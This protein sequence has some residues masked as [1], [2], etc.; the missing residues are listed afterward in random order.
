MIYKVIIDQRLPGTNEY[1]KAQRGGAHAGAELKRNTESD[2]GWLIRGQLHGLQITQPV[3]LIYLW[4]EP[5]T[6][7][8]KDNIRAAEKFVQDAL[9]SLGVLK[10]DGWKY[11]R[12]SHHDCTVDAE[13]PRLELYIVEQPV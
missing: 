13:N 7:R 1:S 9:V 2:I 12:G 11:I 10:G 5:N 8:D 4:C 6:R 3:N